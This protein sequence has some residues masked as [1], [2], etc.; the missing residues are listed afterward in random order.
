MKS[1]QLWYGLPSI[2]PNA[3]DEENVWKYLLIINIHPSKLLGRVISKETMETL[4][5]FQIIAARDGNNMQHFGMCQ[6]RL[7]FVAEYSG[8]VWRL[9]RVFDHDDEGVRGQ[10]RRR[11]SGGTFRR[12]EQKENENEHAD[13]KKRDQR[14]M[15]IF[16]NLDKNEPLT[17][18]FFV[19]PR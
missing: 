17:R 10:S 19:D 15:K 14:F 1:T 6:H 16:K 3:S 7:M 8:Q 11:R 2:V 5:F 12:L 18:I 9:E 13:R 4:N